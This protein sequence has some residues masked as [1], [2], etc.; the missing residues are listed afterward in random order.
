MEVKLRIGEVL[1]SQKMT[2]IELSRKVKKSKVTV[3]YWC[4]N[5]NHPS[6][7]TL[8]LIARVLDVKISDLIKEI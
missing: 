6:L 7:E 5:K 3:N 2:Q 4:S 1:K 8:S